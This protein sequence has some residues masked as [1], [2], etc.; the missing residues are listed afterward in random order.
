MEKW[1]IYMY[2]IYPIHP[3]LSLQHMPHYNHAHNILRHFDGSNFPF[4]TSKRSVS[5]VAE[6]F[7]ILEN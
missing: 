2:N 7:K 4:T 3:I 5:Q 1:E 6:R